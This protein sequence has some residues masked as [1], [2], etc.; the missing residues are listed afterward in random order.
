MA[1]LTLS[2]WQF[3][4]YP[5]A[6]QFDW[7]LDPSLH[8]KATGENIVGSQ[9]VSNVPP[10]I[11]QCVTIMQIITGLPLKHLWV[12]ASVVCPV[13]FQCTYCIWFGGQ[14]VRSLPGMQL[15]MYTT[16]MARAV[17]AKLISFELQPQ[18]HKTT[19]VFMSKTCTEWC[20]SHRA[21]EEQNWY[22]LQSSKFQVY[23]EITETCLLSPVSWCPTI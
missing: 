20:W 6:I 5:V 23:A 8:W 13:V 18:I 4:G 17:W 16:G 14:Q 10:V 9:C 21:S 12:I 7:N 22:A 1:S 11:L 19:M 3:R 15:L 2:Q